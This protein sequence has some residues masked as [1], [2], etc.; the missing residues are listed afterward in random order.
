[1]EYERR[2]KYEAKTVR[3]SDHSV[4][5]ELTMTE[6]KIVRNFESDQSSDSSHRKSGRSKFPKSQKKPAPATKRGKKRGKKL[7]QQNRIRKSE[8]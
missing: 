1:M 6:T 4:S 7:R 5:K 2:L 8:N 3:H